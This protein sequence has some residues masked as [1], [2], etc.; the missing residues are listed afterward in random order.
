MAYAFAVPIPAGKT[1][2]MRRLFAESL[3]PRKREYDD[4]QRRAGITEESYWLQHDPEGDVLV[5]VSNSDQ[6][7]F[8]A[9]M[10]N[11]QTDFDRWFRD[12]LREIFGSDPAEPA[13]ERNEL[14][15][16]WSA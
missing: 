9:I 10:A 4:L 13:G 15:G 5:V 14:L 1:D 16:S 2:A 3:G 11:P 7:D 8:M 12:Q 6:T